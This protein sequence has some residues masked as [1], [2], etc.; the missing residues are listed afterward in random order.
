VSGQQVFIVEMLL[1]FGLFLGWALWELISL[2]RLQKRDRETAAEK[3]RLAHGQTGQD[4]DRSG[5]S[6]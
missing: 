3:A 4:T 1:F 2:R 6:L 5:S